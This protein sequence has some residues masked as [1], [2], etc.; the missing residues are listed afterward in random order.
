MYVLGLLLYPQVKQAQN[1][2][3]EACAEEGKRRDN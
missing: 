2:P 3:Q 1:R